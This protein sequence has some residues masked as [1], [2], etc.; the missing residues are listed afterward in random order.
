MQD[1]KFKSFILDYDLARDDDVDNS[2]L[3][4]AQ[5]ISKIELVTCQL[6]S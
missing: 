1:V 4:M 2:L 5:N 6:Y 3:L